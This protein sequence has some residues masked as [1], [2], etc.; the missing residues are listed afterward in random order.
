MLALVL[1]TSFGLWTSPVYAYAYDTDFESV[2]H[3]QNIGTEIAG[4]SIDVINHLGELTNYPIADI[5]VRGSTSL[6]VGSIGVGSDFKGSAV[7]RSSQP[8]ATVVSQS[9]SGEV[10]NQPLSSGFSEGSANVLIPTVLKNK[11][12]FHSLFSVQNVDTETADLTFTFVPL[13][14]DPPD[15]V[16]AG[17]PIIH[18]ITDLAP[19]VSYFIDMGNFPAITENSFNGSVAI[20]AK[21][22]GSETPGAIVGT[23]MELEIAGYNAYAFDAALNT[24]N[25]IFMPSAVCKFGPNR[26]STSAYAVQNTNNFPIDVKVTYSN[27]NIDGPYTLEAFAK[28]SFDGCQAGNPRGFLGS[29]IIES[30]GGDIHT[31]GKIYGGGLYPAHLGFINGSSNVSLPYIRWTESNWY[32]QIGHR[33]YIAIQNIG[34]TNI[35]AGDV[36]VEYYNKDGTLAG[37]HVLG[38][39]DVSK[40]ANSHPQYIGASGYEFG[41]DGGGAAIVK[42]P[43]GSQ[44]A[45]VV[46]VQRYIGDGNSVGE[47]YTGIPTN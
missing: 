23:S 6:L 21:K 22:A 19:G 1:L 33:T 14:G 46:R 43:I 42:G 4:V 8:L 7:L 41:N 45:V 31:V 18:Q 11:F 16:V 38:A 13:I 17:T 26:N 35:Q 9:S 15:P 29:A 2:I 47:D 25:K 5:P 24:S 28:R 37:T 12:F 3:I 40:K 10:K 44:L 32:N 20:E 27:G 36:V 34:T 39:I 30:T